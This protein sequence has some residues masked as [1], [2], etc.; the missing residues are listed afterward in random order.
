MADKGTEL[1]PVYCSESDF[2]GME[3]L[4]QDTTRVS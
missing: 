1:I 4:S 3:K 2:T